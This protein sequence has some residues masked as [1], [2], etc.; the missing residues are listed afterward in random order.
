MA[1]FVLAV[2]FTLPILI[3]LQLNCVQLVLI[4]HKQTVQLIQSAAIH[5]FYAQLIISIQERV[6][7]HASPVLQDL[8]ALAQQA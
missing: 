6:N 3:M 2:L 5:K 1:I 7:Q 8:T 4:V